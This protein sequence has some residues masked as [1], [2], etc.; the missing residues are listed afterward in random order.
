MN[1]GA[2]RYLVVV[3][4]DFGRSSSINRAIGAAHERGILTSA[5]LMAGG[6]AVLDALLLTRRLPGLSV[7]LH[8]TLCDGRAV[9]PAADIPGLVDASG[10]FPRSPARAWV[11]CSR[12]DLRTQLEREIEAQFERLSQAGIRPTHVDGHHHLHLHPAV[13][14]LVCRLGAKRGVGW[15]RIPDEP[16]RLM[17][18]GPR[19]LVRLAEWIVF[20]R[21]RPFHRRQASLNGLQAADRTYGLSR[22]GSMDARHLVEVIGRGDRVAEVFT[23]PDDAT[24]SG[25]REAAALSAPEVRA[26]LAAS[27]VTPA[28]YGDLPGSA[29]ALSGRGE[30][31]SRT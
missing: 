26:A 28:G 29:A 23:H 24:A 21:L 19:G 22:T 6:K 5:S 20:A 11:A 27:G 7:G 13:F 12:R 14:P 15:V 9:S 31:A 18:G 2:R 30:R 16:F 4:D 17:L 1:T 25:R 8:L 10:H 3:A